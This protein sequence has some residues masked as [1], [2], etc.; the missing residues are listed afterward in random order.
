M[1]RQVENL[2][3]TRKYRPIDHRS[4]EIPDQ[5]I[6]EGSGQALVCA[7]FADALSEI[8]KVRKVCLEDGQVDRSA[9]QSR[10]LRWERGKILNSANF[11][12]NNEST[13]IWQ[14]P[15]EATDLAIQILQIENDYRD[16]LLAALAVGL[17]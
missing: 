12:I 8:R 10:F 9:L 2:V 1:E 11:L 15:T 16:E 14:I 17:S 4:L 5:T 6:P 3:P 7:S 13:A